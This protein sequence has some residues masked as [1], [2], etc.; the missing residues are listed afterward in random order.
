MRIYLS[1]SS[2][3]LINMRK[4]TPYTLLNQGSYRMKYLE[5]YGIQLSS[6]QGHGSYKILSCGIKS[7]DFRKFCGYFLP[8]MSKFFMQFDEQFS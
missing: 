1:I 4:S 2:Y 7:M 8:V 6:F 5:N 3:V